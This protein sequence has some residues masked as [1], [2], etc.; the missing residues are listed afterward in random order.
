[1]RPIISRPRSFTR[2]AIERILRCCDFRT[3]RWV[4]YLRTVVN[5]CAPRIVGA[6]GQSARQPFVETDLT[7]MV[8]GATRVRTDTNHTS[9]RILARTSGRS[10]T[11]D[12]IALLALVECCT[13]GPYIPDAQYAVGTQFSLDLETVLVGIRRPEVGGKDGLVQQRRGVQAKREPRETGIAVRFRRIAECC[14]KRERACNIQ[15]HVEEGIIVSSR[16]TTTEDKI[17]EQVGSR[18]AK[19]PIETK[20]RHDVVRI[21]RRS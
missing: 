17:P 20:T 9:G 10:T 4:E 7:R 12:R 15:R 2:I 6:T 13:F 19:V 3:R 21:P 5:K 14:R 16:V 18:P 1:M 11:Y 8:D